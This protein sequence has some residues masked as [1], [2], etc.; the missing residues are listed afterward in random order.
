MLIKTILK[1]LF[2]KK[3]SSILIIIQVAITVIILVYSY[4][5]IRML[6]YPQK[7]MESV[8]IH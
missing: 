7:Q 5:S 3:L 4:D 8:L 6:D 2:K 1:G